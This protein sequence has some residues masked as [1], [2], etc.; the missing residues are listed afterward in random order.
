MK[1]ASILFVLFLIMPLSIIQA[2]SSVNDISLKLTKLYDGI[3]NSND[4]NVKNA[5]NDSIKE[6]IRLY[7]SSE[8]IFTTKLKEVKYI[9]EIVSPDNKLKIINWNMFDSKGVNHYFCYLIHRNGKKKHTSYLE[10]I[11]KEESI[12]IEK[13]FNSSDWYGALYYDIQNFKFEGKELYLI[14]G[15]D[16]SPLGLSRK[17]IETVSFTNNEPSFGHYNCLNKEGK[18]V[19]R[20]VLEYSSDGMV[21]L[22]FLSRKTIVFDHLAS[23]STGHTMDADGYGAALSFDAYQLEKGSWRFISNVDVRNTK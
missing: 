5:T 14:L 1:K 23:Y 3:V 19:K 9:G 11:Y 7:T 6:L 17:I 13:E 4:D 18:N 12:E 20:E 15:Y 10:G 22:R 8:D 16:Y 2:Q 21:T